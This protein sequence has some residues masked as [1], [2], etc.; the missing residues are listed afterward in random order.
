MKHSDAFEIPTINGTVDD[1]AIKLG[2]YNGL[3]AQKTSAVDF[4]SSLRLIG[5]H[6][7]STM[8]NKKCKLKRI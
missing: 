7:V 8:C 5:K 4:T 2:T 1:V 6:Y 3:N